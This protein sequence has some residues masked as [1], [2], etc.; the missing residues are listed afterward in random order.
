MKKVL[1]VIF[2]GSL[3]FN[4][5]NAQEKST[6]KKSSL[7]VGIKAGAN[8]S[9]VYDTEGENFVADGKFGFAGGAFVTIP[10]ASIIGFQ[11][12]ILFSQRGFKATG[13][14]LGSS[15]SY[16]RTTGHLDIP[17]LLS[18]KPS[19]QVSILVGPQFSYLLS[20]KNEYKSAVANSLQEQQFENDNVRKNMLSLIGG[21]DFNLTNVV[22][23][24]R[25]GWDM[26]QNNGDG[27]SSTPRYK[28]MWYQAT[29][30][31]KLL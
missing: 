4:T 10:I 1:F 22:L 11:P 3:M 14:L 17:L 18:I 13:S 7:S 24:L 12:E 6:T 31:F 28:N 21:L 8:Y 20:Q 30:G 9:N 2:A 26:Q 29:I 15:Y 23:G 25:G 27:T 16:T 5:S 19:S